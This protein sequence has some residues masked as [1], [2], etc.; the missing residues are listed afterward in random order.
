MGAAPWMAVPSKES[1][2][3]S[4][5]ELRKN[6]S[7]MSMLSS[8]KDGCG[9]T[10]VKRL[11][12]GTVGVES[13]VVKIGELLRDRSCVCHD[14]LGRDDERETRRGRWA[15]QRDSTR[16]A[17][18]FLSY[19]R[20]RAH[21][22]L[23]EIFRKETEKPDLRMAK[24][25]IGWRCPERSIRTNESNLCEMLRQLPVHFRESMKLGGGRVDVKYLKHRLSAPQRGETLQLEYL[26]LFARRRRDA[27]SGSFP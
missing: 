5:Y 6:S 15:G 21:A 10:D 12:T 1:M 9:E 8:T 2:E 24:Y 14:E 25:Y 27:G 22:Q 26:D 23:S 13:G 17:P 20:S 7:E 11:K 18:C 3:T 16:T 4:R 19:S